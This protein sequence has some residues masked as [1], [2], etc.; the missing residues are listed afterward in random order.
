MSQHHRRYVAHA[1]LGTVAAHITN[2]QLNLSNLFY[3]VHRRNQSPQR[4]K[5]RAD[6]GRQY[7]A[8]LHIRNKTALSFM[9]ANQHFPFFSDKAH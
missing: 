5:H 3:R 6:M 7:V 1:D 2:G 8:L 9:K 4:Q